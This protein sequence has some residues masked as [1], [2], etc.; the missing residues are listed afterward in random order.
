MH[1]FPL[2][3]KQYLSTIYINIR[4]ILC[5]ILCISIIQVY[6][7]IVTIIIINIMCTVC[8]KIYGVRE[9]INYTC[10]CIFKKNSYI[11]IYFPKSS[12]SVRFG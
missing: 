8:G 7:Y 11:K 12:N 6:M 10:R 4:I 2:Q 1:V 5:I 9:S 3:I